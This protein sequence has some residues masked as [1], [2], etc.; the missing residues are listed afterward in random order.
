MGDAFRGFVDG[1]VEMLQEQ[2]ERRKE[3]L[4][5][6]DYDTARRHGRDGRPLR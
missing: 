6:V 5:E 3:I 4:T 1:F 2:I